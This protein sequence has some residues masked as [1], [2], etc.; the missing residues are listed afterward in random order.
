MTAVAIRC[1][2]HYD[3]D[4]SALH[5]HPHQPRIHC[6]IDF[7]TSRLDARFDAVRIISPNDF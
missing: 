2:M 4:S 5:S 3:R 1:R 7:S 6:R